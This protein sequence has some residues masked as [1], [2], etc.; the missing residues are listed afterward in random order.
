MNPSSLVTFLVFLA[1]TLA[2]TAWASRRSGSRSEFYVAGNAITGM[3]NGFAFAGEIGR[4][5][6]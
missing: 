1:I 5:H 6:V 4:A 3:Q 2:I